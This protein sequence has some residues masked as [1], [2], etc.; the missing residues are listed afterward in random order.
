MVRK[1]TSFADV[2]FAI[3]FAIVKLGAATTS[4]CFGRVG[5]RSP[6]SLNLFINEAQHAEQARE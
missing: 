1:N 4:A 6:L 2:G 3:G 5:G